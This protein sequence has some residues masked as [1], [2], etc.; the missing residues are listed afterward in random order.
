VP[1]GHDPRH[2]EVKFRDDLVVELDA[3]R[4]PRDP[5]GR[6]LSSARSE[7]VLR[8]LRGAGARWDRVS[9]VDPRRVDEM[10]YRAERSLRRA[11][12]DFND[13]FVLTLPPGADAAR[14]MDELNALPEVE[15][16][17]PLPLPVPAP[18]PGDFTSF[19]GYL[20]P[21]P[22]GIDAEGAWTLPGGTGAGVTICDLEYSWNLSHLDLTPVA[23]FLAP[24]FT[25]SDPFNSTDHGTAVLGEMASHPNGWGTT[26]ASHGVGRAVAPVFLNGFYALTTALLQVS[27]HLEAG[28][29]ILIEQQAFGPRAGFVPVEW[30]LSVYNAILLAVG[31]G[32]HVV[33]AAG[34]GD[35]DLDDPIYQTGH[36]PFLPENDSGA[37]MVGA[38]A[39]PPSAFGSDVDRSR[40][41]FSNYGSRVNVQGWGEGVAT[42]GYGDLHNEGDNLTY[43]A[44]FA[45]TSSASPIIASAVASIEGVVEAET[46]LPAHPAL[47]RALLERTGRRSNREDIPPRPIRSVRDPT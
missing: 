39:A 21:A 41:Y 26:G 20:G 23:T 28:D 37:I 29:V 36:A 42:T 3:A 22:A 25:A 40:L 5:T 12:A 35:E 6:G 11:I 43:T 27:S 44:Y 4:T 32:I 18:L 14:W 24:G 31:N 1:P 38:G 45:G 33:E 30:N 8:D 2:I 34:N 47:L 19:Q 46:G 9:G 7:R 10:R 13:Y 15:L 17:S 16:A